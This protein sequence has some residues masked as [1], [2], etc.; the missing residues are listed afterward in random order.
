[1][2][3]RAH[4]VA[5]SAATSTSGSV[6]VGKTHSTMGYSVKGQVPSTPLTRAF[7]SLWRMSSCRILC[8]VM[9]AGSTEGVS[10]I[11]LNLN[12]I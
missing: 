3:E 4:E 8:G 12:E 6:A 11:M 10:D 7:S 1:M 9:I 5:G 2:I